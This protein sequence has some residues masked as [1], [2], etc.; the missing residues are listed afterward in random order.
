[1]WWPTQPGK[2]LRVNKAF[3][4]LVGIKPSAILGRTV[5]DLETE[6][7]FS[8]SVLA[9]VLKEKKRVTIIQ[10]NLYRHRGYRYRSS[11]VR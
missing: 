6:K 10:K 3:E 8:P 7:I 9:I 4:T 11:V 5:Y 1:M 2:L